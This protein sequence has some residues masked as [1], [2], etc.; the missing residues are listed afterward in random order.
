MCCSRC[1]GF[2]CITPPIFPARVGSFT[3]DLN[4][5]AN[6]QNGL[7]A[8]LIV[9]FYLV[10]LICVALTLGQTTRYVLIED[11]PRCLALHI[12]TVRLLS[13][14]CVWAK[15]PG[16]PPMEVG[17]VARRCLHLRYITATISTMPSTRVKRPGML[18]MKAGRVA[19]L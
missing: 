8:L 14:L 9:S 17:R 15:R 13:I 11:R 10:A 19:W 1:L 7:A 16:I 12:V 18:S 3:L 6:P 2:I 5:P 4:D